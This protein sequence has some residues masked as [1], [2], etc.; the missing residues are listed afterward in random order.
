VASVI[1]AFKSPAR[2]LYG[3]QS[4]LK[5]ADKG[6]IGSL[7]LLIFDFFNDIDPYETS[8][9]ISCCSSE[10]GFSLYQSAHLSRY[11]AAS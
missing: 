11:D 9:S 1:E 2:V 8:A 6:S 7:A 5:L 10:A 4:R 3:R